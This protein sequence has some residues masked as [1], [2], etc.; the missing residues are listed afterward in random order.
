MTM[1]TTNMSPE[2]KQAQ[3]AVARAK[4]AMTNAKRQMLTAKL[5]LAL[6]GLDEWTDEQEKEWIELEKQERSL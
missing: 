2:Q 4:Q 1:T 6:A 3:S 5:M